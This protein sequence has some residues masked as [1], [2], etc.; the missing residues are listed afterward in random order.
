MLDSF[1]DTETFC[2]TPINHGTHKYAEDAEVMLWSYALNDDTVKVWDRVN[3]RIHWQDDLSGVWQDAPVKGMP[4]DLDAMLREHLVWFH[5]GG[6]FDFV[7]LS[8]D[9]PQA[10]G[11]IAEDRKRDTMVQAYCHALPGSLDKLGEVLDLVEDERKIKEGKKLVRLFCI[12]QNED[13][14]KKY[15]TDRATK[16]TH[17][18]EWQRFIEYAGG[19][20]TT[21]RAARRLMPQWNYKAGKQMD[22]WLADLRMNMRGFAVDLDL[23]NAAVHMAE[24]VQEDL[25][26]RTH[27]ATDGEVASATQRDALKDYLASVGVDLPDLRADTLERRMADPDLPEAVKELIGIRLMASMNSVS[28][29]K[30]LLKG[31]SRDGRLRGCHQFRGAGR[32]GRWAHRLFQPGNLPRPTL[33]HDLIEYAIEHM[34]LN[35]LDAMELVFGSVMAAMSSTIRG[36]IVAP[37]GRKLVVADLS[38]IE[39]RVAA[40]LAGEE[41]KLQ[42]F[43]DYDTT[44]VDEDGVIEIDEK[45]KP[46]RKGLDLY[47]KAYMAS[48]NVTDPALVGKDERQIG[49]VEEL[50]FQYGGGVGAWIT[51]AATYG[52]D[53]DK[54]TGQVW[55]VLP[56]WAKDEAADFLQWLYD[57]EDA[58]YAKAR[59]KAI[60]KHEG[61]GHEAL[62][63]EL[64]R[65]VRQRE[66]AKLKARHNLPEK[67]FVCCDAI[68]RLWRKAHPRITSYWEEIEDTVREAIRNPGVTL[69]CRKIKVRRDGAWLRCGL[70]SGRALCYP[71]PGIDK[72]GRIYYTG[73][74]VYTRQWGKVYSYGGKF[75]ENWVQAVACDQFAE[76][77][78]EIEEA[79]YMPVLGVHDEWVTETPDEDKYTAA[80]LA[81]MMCK[82]LGWNHGL[83]LAAAG[84][85][86]YRYR[87]AD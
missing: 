64:D 15:G 33:S 55:D 46:R 14:V 50:M 18:A 47:I 76:P 23:A 80:E 35:A 69:E 7:V 70:P 12:P 24:Q 4:V 82:D 13:F 3:G 44:L 87:K 77:M 8:H 65:L 25:A 59:D 11:L 53:L 5:N 16:Q 39:G 57:M 54:M 74:S 1:H 36:A 43:R 49:K 22:L 45:G 2:R 10:Y 34:K 61:L 30:T 28:K 42:A 75:F 79:G 41:W 86:A 60:E 66:A 29:F 84:F 40:W 38:N 72:E 68:K 19:D 31:V 78:I 85:E 83:P 51:G 52:I 17:P 81:R 48:F 6:Q 67:T 27:E 62:N 9:M 63:E 71:N 32:T 21:M 73:Y 37:P 56:S 26:A 20:I 58:K